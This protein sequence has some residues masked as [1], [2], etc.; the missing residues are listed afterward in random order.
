V[1]AFIQRVSAMPSFFPVNAW[2]YHPCADRE[3]MVKYV[4][5]IQRR[6]TMDV[7]KRLEFDGYCKK[8]AAMIGVFAAVLIFTSIGG[9]GLPFAARC[10]GALAGELSVCAM[11]TLYF[12]MLSHAL[13][14]VMPDK[15]TS[16][17]YALT[18]ALSTAMKLYFVLDPLSPCSENALFVKFAALTLDAFLQRLYA[19]KLSETP[20]DTPHEP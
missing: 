3:N 19:A 6:L 12:D 5:H 16:R 7:I 10:F 8:S 11:L 2:N 1:T 9:D 14:A 4:H 17:T 13:S 18:G 20:A 15:S